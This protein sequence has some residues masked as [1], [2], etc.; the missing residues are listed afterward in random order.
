MLAVAV[1]VLVGACTSA[2]TLSPIGSAPLSKEVVEHLLTKSDVEAIGGDVGGLSRSIDAA[3]SL[4][5]ESLWNLRWTAGGKPG[6][7]V[8]LTRFREA[9]MAHALLD[10]IERGLAYRAMDEA[11]GDRSVFSAANSGT[12][13]AVT[14]LRDRTLV[15]LQLP[16]A[17]DGAVLLNEE[18][19]IN[20]ATLIEAK[21]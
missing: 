10:K 11:I 17:G 20:L 1:V 21:F 8:T 18:Q 14:F 13:A 15:A 16:I 4:T 12:G 6:L 19:L 5:T 7:L 2:G 9:P 3:V